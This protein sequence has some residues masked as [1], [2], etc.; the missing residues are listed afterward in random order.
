[1]LVASGSEVG[2]AVQ[3]AGILEAVVSVRVVSIPGKELFTQQAASVQEQIIPSSARVVVVEAARGMGW[4][5]LF[6]Q[7]LLVLG[8]E[9]FGASAPS[10]VLAEKFG[11]TGRIVAARVSEWLQK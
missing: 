11:F 6:R 10:N 9:R 1:V 2:V 7:R 4:G 5:D 3:A 8:I